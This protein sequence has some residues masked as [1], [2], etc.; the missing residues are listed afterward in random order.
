MGDMRARCENRDGNAIVAS[1]N[2]V[3]EQSDQPHAKKLMIVF[4][5]GSPSADRYRGDTAI[6]HTRKCVK[7]TETKGWNIIQL[8][9]SGAHE[10]YMKRMFTNW[11]YIGN[12]SDT[13]G[14]QTAKI[15]RKV[16]KI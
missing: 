4:S 7:Y 3:K 1:A 12:A 10:Y 6:N 15:I 2:R 5:D 8:G 9:F 13:L 16:L 14:D 11:I